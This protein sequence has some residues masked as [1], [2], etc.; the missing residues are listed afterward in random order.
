MKLPV[1]ELKATEMA[2]HTKL[3]LLGAYVRRL[4]EATGRDV[5]QVLRLFWLET[6]KD[7]NVDRDAFRVWAGKTVYVLES[8]GIDPF[9]DFEE[10]AR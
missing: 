10:M 4:T 8:L 9:E 1:D 3:A 2:E 6:G 5:P 7:G